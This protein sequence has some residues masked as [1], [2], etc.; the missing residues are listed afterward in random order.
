VPTSWRKLGLIDDRFATLVHPSCAIA[1]STVIGSGSILLAGVVATA[2]VELGRHVVAMPNTVFTHDD[3]VGDF[4]TFGAHALVAG[5]VSIGAGTYI[6]AG[7]KV[8]ESLTIGAGALVGMGSVVTHDIPA[9]ERGPVYRPAGSSRRPKEYSCTRADSA[10]ATRSARA[11]GCGRS[12]TLLDGAVVG[13]H[14]NICDHAYVEGGARLGNNVTVK[15]GV[16]IS[17]W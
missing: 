13:E 11:R 9:G 7:A 1:P 3:R 10:R 8:R 5:R 4:V 6:G 17:T 12:R 15:N 2:D 16:L 14:C